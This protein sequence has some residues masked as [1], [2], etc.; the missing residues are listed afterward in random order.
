MCVVKK[1]EELCGND[2]LSF[3]LCTVTQ[4]NAPANYSRKRP[5]TK[6]SIDVTGHWQLTYNGDEAIETTFRA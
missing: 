1:A 4:Y 5:Q 6:R 2:P 3:I